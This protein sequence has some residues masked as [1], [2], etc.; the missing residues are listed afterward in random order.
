[1]TRRH[2]E[3]DRLNDIDRL[4]TVDELKALGG[5]THN[6]KHTTGYMVAL[7]GNE[8]VIPA[9]ICTNG[10]W[11]MYYIKH[12]PTKKETYVGAWFNPDDDHFY[13]DVSQWVEDKEEALVLGER[14][15]Q[16]A[17]YEI[18]TG[19]CIPCLSSSSFS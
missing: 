6:L 11:G 3:L 7:A 9:D 14:N 1:M 16:L 15:Q 2:S 13:F 18:E 19:A 5:Y 10:N 12:R 17:I 8:V 4:P